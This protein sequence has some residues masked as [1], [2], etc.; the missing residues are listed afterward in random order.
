M[1]CT[2][3]VIPGPRGPGLSTYLPCCAWCSALA[4]CCC[5]NA[6][7]ATAPA[8]GRCSAWAW[9]SLL[10]WHY[11][12][13]TK[14]IV[15]P[16]RLLLPLCALLSTP[17]LAADVQLEVEIPRLQ[18]AEYHRPYVAIWLEQPDQK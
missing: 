14:D 4:A 10:C 18:V 1:T 2:R 17:V 11:C 8:P 5:C 7:P 9:Y 16:K 6:M 15:M 13:F 12:L 3:A